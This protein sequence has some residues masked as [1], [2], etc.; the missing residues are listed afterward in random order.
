MPH[1]PPS[2]R[3]IASVMDK[4][5]AALEKQEGNPF[6]IKAY[7]A[8]AKYVRT[9]DKPLADF[10]AAGDRKGMEAL[11]VIGEGLANLIFEYVRTGQ[12]SLLKRLEG[13][14][15][16]EY[17]FE[18]IPGIGKTFAH[19][20]AEKLDVKTLEDLEHAAY[21]GSLAAVEGFGKRRLEAVRASLAGMLGSRSAE[22]MKK[23]AR[24]VPASDEPPVSMVL[25]FDKD[26]RAK[27]AAGKLKTIAPK[28]FNPQKEA[29][30][31]VLHDD[32][33]GWSLT[34]LFS[35]TVRAHLLG[36]TH[37][38]VVVFY[39]KKKSEGQCTVVT[40]TSGPLKGKRVVRGR[41][42]ECLAYY[43]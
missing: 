8:G 24:S 5:A 11:P 7:R 27:A 12:S 29:W 3:D 4:V 9:L 33:D 43:K 40:E 16:P 31:P 17:L 28:R 35:N 34:A 19:R 18:K 38:W 10:V 6:K 36:K 25:K 14:I 26:Y 1:K 15:S 2:N 20:I 23:M 13:S 37:D 21:D 30:L 41:E 32:I 39:D 22:R 42:D